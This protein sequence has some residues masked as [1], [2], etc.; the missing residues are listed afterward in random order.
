MKKNVLFFF[1]CTLIGGAETNILRISR[2]LTNSGYNVF[3]CY[4]ENNGPLLKLVDFDIK[5]HM[6]TGLFLKNPSRFYSRYK[7]FVQINQIDI[8]FNFGLRVE[9]I[10]RIISKALGVKRIIS[11]I[12]STDDW[13]KWYHTLLDRLT[14]SSVDMWVSNSIA[15]KVAFNRREKI[16]PDKIEVIYNFYEA[17]EQSNKPASPQNSEVLKIGILANITKEKGYL[18]LISLSKELSKLNLIHKFIYAG[19][20]KLNGNFEREIIAN[21]LEDRFEYLGYIKNKEEFFNKIDLFFLP[22]YLEGFPT[23]IL[24]AMAFKKP[25]IATNVG[26][27][28]EL[29]SDGVDGLLC[30]AGDI[31]CYVEHILALKEAKRASILVANCERKLEKFSKIMIMNRWKSVIDNDKE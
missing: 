4:L 6:E 15:G 18:D 12:R 22:T 31:G 14:L 13:R 16:N 3:W 7:R 5:G 23:V 21:E 1:S 27:I 24:E 28:P 8:V 9:L 10:S 2:E 29:I 26:G 17:I 19:V 11:N 30:A 25:I 20:D